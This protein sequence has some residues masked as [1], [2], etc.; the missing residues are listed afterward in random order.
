VAHCYIEAADS[1]FIAGGYGISDLWLPGMR[2][3]WKVGKNGD[4]QE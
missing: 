3:T 1:F 4:G 2:R